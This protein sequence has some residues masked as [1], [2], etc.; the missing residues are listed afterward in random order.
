MAAYSGIII[1][2]ELGRETRIERIMFR[3]T[4]PLSDIL[5]SIEAALHKMEETESETKKLLQ[6]T[7]IDPFTL[8]PIADCSVCGLNFNS[9][10]NSPVD[11]SPSHRL[12]CSHMI[13]ETC[14]KSWLA[15]AGSCPVCRYK[16]TD[17]IFVKKYLDPRNKAYSCPILEQICFLGRTYL[18]TNR[19]DITFRGFYDWAKVQETGY[20]DREIENLERAFEPFS[21]TFEESAIQGASGQDFKTD[22]WEKNVAWLAAD[23]TTDI[24]LAMINGIEPPYRDSP[25][26]PRDDYSGSEDSGDQSAYAAS[27]DSDDDSGPNDRKYR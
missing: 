22:F 25:L 23:M 4:L 5:S 9:A 16:L 19:A 17:R 6:T 24:W 18:Q 12:P 7:R 15:V 11:I 10:G 2:E 8:A 26:S 13:C 14:L 27:N 21:T 1:A 20:V 3:M